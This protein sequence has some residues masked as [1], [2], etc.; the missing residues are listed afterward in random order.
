MRKKEEPKVSI[1][2]Y[3]DKLEG[4]A[5]SDDDIKCN[6]AANIYFLRNF[7]NLSEQNLADIL[8]I[9]KNTVSSYENNRI[10]PSITIL[11]K[12]SIIFGI[13]I[14]T[15][16][17]C[18]L[19]NMF[20]S[21]NKLNKAEHPDATWSSTSFSDPEYKKFIN[22]RYFIYYFDS[23]TSEDITVNKEDI[24]INKMDIK[25]IRNFEKQIYE[26]YAQINN[27]VK[28]YTGTLVL[29]RTYHAYIYLR[30]MN[31]YER[32]LITFQFPDNGPAKPYI[33]GIGLISSI[34]SGEFK[35]PCAQKTLIS[36]ID[37]NMKKYN[38]DINSFL[39]LNE[40]NNGIIKVTPLYKKIN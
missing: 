30:G 5:L 35:Y 34:S 8:N 1:K 2:K 10:K 38:N 26:A 11:N 19:T 29:T 31:H 28:T 3:M 32:V 7:H 27:S 21:E 12:L 6:I 40:N 22:N 24:T 18:D 33:G 16:I 4:K 9:E 17:D 39:A 20:N 37:I 23:H 25:F 13:S 36:Y 14:N 15:I